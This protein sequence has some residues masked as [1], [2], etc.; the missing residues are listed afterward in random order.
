V[1]ENCAPGTA[2]QPQTRCPSIR[3]MMRGKT[4]QS[5]W[6]SGARP[7]LC[8]D[9]LDERQGVEHPREPDA[10]DPM[11]QGTDDFLLKD[12]AT[13]SAPRLTLR[14]SS[15]S[16]RGRPRRLPP[17]G[18]RFGH[19]ALRSAGGLGEFP[20]PSMAP[21]PPYPVGTLLGARTQASHSIG[22]VLAPWRL[23]LPI[24]SALASELESPSHLFPVGFSLHGGLSSLIA[25]S[26]SDFLVLTPGAAS[27]AGACI[28][29]R[30]SSCSS[31]PAWIRILL[32]A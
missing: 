23:V 18:S 5:G 27:P 17:P 22:R 24:R 11:D 19:P 29:A 15:P 7:R 32:G 8:H 30:Y 13:T 6:D 4:R 10:G 14:T 1:L 20:A 31:E 25:P 26:R 21:F 9:R 2:N 16:L 3:R 28:H 12:S